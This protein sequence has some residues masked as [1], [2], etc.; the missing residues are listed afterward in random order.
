LLAFYGQSAPR[1]AVI[2][3]SRR[4]KS[5]GLTIGI[6]RNCRSGSKCL[7][8]PLTASASKIPFVVC[9]A[10]SLFAPHGPRWF[11]PQ[12]LFQVGCGL[13]ESA[14]EHELVSL[15]RVFALHNQPNP[16]LKGIN[17]FHSKTP[18]KPV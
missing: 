8:S 12:Q 10:L 13:K 7:L 2:Y 11:P 5:D 16:S 4:R 6:P 17:A 1:F 14:S 9:G 3:F 18:P 15:S